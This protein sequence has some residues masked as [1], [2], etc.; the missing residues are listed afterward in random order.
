METPVSTLQ[1]AEA[2]GEPEGSSYRTQ[3]CIVSKRPV[4]AAQRLCSFEPG[5]F[6]SVSSSSLPPHWA[7][8]SNKQ[9]SSKQMAI[10]SGF[11]K[12]ESWNLDT[13]PPTVTESSTC[14][15]KGSSWPRPNALCGSLQ[16]AWPTS[17]PTHHHSTSTAKRLGR[18]QML[19]KM[20]TQIGAALCLLPRHQVPF[21]AKD[22]TSPHVPPAGRDCACFPSSCR[23]QD[24]PPPPEKV[25]GRGGRSRGPSVSLC[26]AASFW[27]ITRSQCSSP[28]RGDSPPTE[29]LSSPLWWSPEPSLKKPY[30]W[31]PLLG[32]AA[33]PHLEKA[34]FGPGRPAARVWGWADFMTRSCP[35]SGLLTALN[36]LREEHEG[37]KAGSFLFTRGLRMPQLGWAATVSEKSHFLLRPC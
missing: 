30:T 22:N 12:A 8:H 21:L 6:G 34:G 7:K 1:D 32:Q 19:R 9:H 16:P 33:Q 23:A 35:F 31:G 14:Q 28:G 29:L 20:Y 27:G 3:P 10:S 26:L 15:L 13:L 24:P 17:I 11:W 2:R 36:S 37:P 25:R 5:N 4:P 18:S